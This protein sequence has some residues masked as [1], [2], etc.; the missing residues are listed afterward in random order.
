MHTGTEKQFQ[1]S[2][3][4]QGLDTLLSHCGVLDGEDNL[5]NPG[6]SILLG[7][8]NRLH[9]ICSR[10]VA[11]LNKNYKNRNQIYKAELNI[12]TH[13]TKK[14]LRE[15]E[16]RSHA[17]PR[18]PSRPMSSL[19]MDSPR[20]RNL[21]EQ[22]TEEPEGGKDKEESGKNNIRKDF[23]AW[24]YS[25]IECNEDTR[26]ARA[27]GPKKNKMNRKTST[28]AEE[29]VS[30]P[31]LIREMRRPLSAM[32]SPSVKRPMPQTEFTRD[33][34]T[35][36]SFGASVGFGRPQS[37][38]SMRSGSRR[39]GNSRVGNS[40][41]GNSRMSSS[42]LSHVSN[43]FSEYST[44]NSSQWNGNCDD[45][46]DNS[47]G[48]GT[49]MTMNSMVSYANATDIWNLA[50]EIDQTSQYLPPLAELDLSTLGGGEFV[51]PFCPAVAHVGVTK[52]L[53][54]TK[55]DDSGE[56][57]EVEEE[58]D[59]GE[60]RE[61]LTKPGK[62]SDQQNTAN[63]NKEKEGHGTAND[64]DFE[65]E[66]LPQYDQT[67]KTL[68][69]PQHAT[70]HSIVLQ[71]ATPRNT[72]TFGNA[73]ENPRGDNPRDR[74]TRLWSFTHVSFEK[75]SL[76]VS[77]SWHSL[78]FACHN[79]VLNFNFF[80][81]SFVF[82]LFVLF[83][84]RLKFKL[85]GTW[86]KSARRNN[87]TLHVARRSTKIFVQKNPHPFCKFAMDRHTLSRSNFT[88]GTTLFV[89]AFVRSFLFVR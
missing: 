64:G 2:I 52:N 63:K 72:M 85:T 66:I 23:M 68:N 82:F 26:D 35:P 54:Y 30:N 1:T 51:S 34:V 10:C 20:K 45:D 14:Y 42:R 8:Q 71:P 59:D 70:E 41:V 28:T 87:D 11:N 31:L 48:R 15:N 4:K 25:S 74:E 65:N 73:S 7:T 24:Y 5:D 56:D 78:F 57:T 77:Q 32:F 53:D 84:H 38:M 19:S 12:R 76:W 67:S 88:N 75:V 86:C 80:F 37:Q 83:N 16:A 39:M 9:Q 60:E 6:S 58:N 50:D 47:G 40:R 44:Y 17:S 22:Q 18:P 29:S 49:S 55:E 27:D 62:Q 69:G 33:T 61:P 89:F 21:K 43:T 36:S 79:I 81:F 3:C 13:V 46:Y